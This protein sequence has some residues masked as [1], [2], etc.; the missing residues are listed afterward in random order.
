MKHAYLRTSQKQEIKRAQGNQ[1]E[2]NTTVSA[3][4]KLARS[5]Q[6]VPQP[7]RRDVIT[8]VDET[9]Q[10]LEQVLDRAVPP[11]FARVL[12]TASA[13]LDVGI[14]VGTVC[15]VAEY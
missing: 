7:R 9:R 15:I 11:V 8:E 12:G 5:I 14:Q 2:T 13:L 1:T 6:A 4:R 10:W 3:P